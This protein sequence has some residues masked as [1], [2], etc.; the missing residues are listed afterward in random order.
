MTKYR[1]T[2]QR[3]SRRE[4]Y[5]SRSVAA[6]T[7]AILAIAACLWLMIEIVLN[8]L[9][10]PG[11][12]ATPAGMAGA[13]AGVSSAPPVFVGGLGLTGA[14]IGLL[15]LVVA[16]TPGRRS[17]HLLETERAATIVDNEV[18]ASALAREA[19]RVAGLAPDNARVTVTPRSAT[20]HLTPTS[21]TAIDQQAVL[22]A[23]REQIVAFGLLR[24]LHAKV[25]VV[26]TGRVGG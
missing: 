9:G 24:S 8:L 12:L 17:R 1:S 7:L 15:L 5:S 18:I 11:L 16:V 25:V 14:L 22:T 3:L 2:Y 20:V 13:V 26:S 19:A 6:I 21:G 10:R 23:V 4:L